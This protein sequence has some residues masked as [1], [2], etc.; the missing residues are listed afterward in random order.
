MTI[1]EYLD[2]IAFAAGRIISTLWADHDHLL[3]IQT[4]ISAMQELVEDGYRRADFLQTI[5][6]DPDDVAEGVGMRFETYFGV[7]KELSSKEHIGKKLQEQIAAR[8]FSI[9]SLASALLQQ[10]KQ[11]IS[12]AHGN[13]GDCPNGRLIGT[14]PLKTVIWQARN[15]ALHWEDRTFNQSVHQCFDALAND[16]DPMF[17]D[18]TQRCMA[19]DILELFAWKNVESFRHDMLSL[20][21]RMYLTT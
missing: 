21:E 17:A 9:D 19:F 8:S 4:Q 6:E 11:G 3:R 1:P 14:Q 12:I 5:A 18:Y 2:E 10:A 16:I 13:L 15:Q 20:R 7:G